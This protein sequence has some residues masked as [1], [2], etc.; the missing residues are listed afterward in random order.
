MVAKGSKL[1]RISYATAINGVK[2]IILAKAITKLLVP[3]PSRPQSNI[4]A[5]WLLSTKI[6]GIQ[7]INNVDKFLA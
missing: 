1:E 2:S 3:L 6:C 7:H 5:V 4:T